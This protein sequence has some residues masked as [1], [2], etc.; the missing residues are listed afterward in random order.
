M[1]E[2]FGNNQPDATVAAYL[3]ASIVRYSGTRIQSMVP[4]GLGS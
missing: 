3:V 4:V 2:K 1:N